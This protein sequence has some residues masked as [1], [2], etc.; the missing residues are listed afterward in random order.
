MD[1]G[2][3]GRPVLMEDGPRKVFMTAASDIPMQLSEVVSACPL[4][5]TLAKSEVTLDDWRGI[6]LSKLVLALV[7]PKANELPLG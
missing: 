5:S 1:N 7:L 6:R 4:S 2:D 3:E